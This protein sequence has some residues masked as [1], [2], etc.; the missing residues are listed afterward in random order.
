M[1]GLTRSG[2]VPDTYEAIKSRIESKLEALNP[3]FDFSPESPDGQLIGIMAFEIFQGWSQ[4][5][6]VYNSYN[7]QVAS[8]AALRNLGLI[9]GLPYGVANRSFAT[10][11]VTGT[12][13]TIIPQGTILT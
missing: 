7:P 1:A 8:G 12:A 2:F 3:G 4:L 13:G 9:S 10:C 5:N 6:N 11:E